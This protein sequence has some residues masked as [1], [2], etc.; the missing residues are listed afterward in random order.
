M[1]ETSG[2]LGCYQFESTGDSEL[3]ARP[4]WH[5]VVTME[6]DDASSCCHEDLG[7]ERSGE[8]DSEGSEG[9]DVAVKDGGGGEL[10]RLETCVLTESN[11]GMGDSGS[12]KERS[13][14]FWEACLAS[15]L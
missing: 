6:E 8:G 2:L 3:D 10:E 12:E 11:G 4:S 14:L 15:N 13:R 5:G 7:S 9:E 1:G